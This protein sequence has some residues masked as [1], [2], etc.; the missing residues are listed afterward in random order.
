MDRLGFFKR[1]AV[2]AGSP[3]VI[4]RAIAAVPVKRAIAFNRMHYHGEIQWTND[5]DI[6]AMFAA[7]AEGF[8]REISRRMAATNPYMDLIE[9]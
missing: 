6:N 7:K 8:Q 3:A 4:E 9:K 1:L 5:N 2:L